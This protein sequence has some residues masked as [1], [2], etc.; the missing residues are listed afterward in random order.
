M[1]IEKSRTNL[2][3]VFAILINGESL[4]LSIGI[5]LHA[6]PV[7]FAILPI[8]NTM[9]RAIG[10]PEGTSAL[11]DCV[12]EF[13]SIIPNEMCPLCAVGIIPD[14]F[15]LLVLQKLD[16]LRLEPLGGYEPPTLDLEDPISI[17]ELQG[18]N[19]IYIAKWTKRSPFNEKLLG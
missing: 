12:I 2:V 11:I 15:H 10:I 3:M 8:L 19:S 1:V 7:T 17:F 6:F 14:L 13:A 18:H 5:E 16:G 9:S 4:K